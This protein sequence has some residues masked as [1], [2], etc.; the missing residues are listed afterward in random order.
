MPHN[1]YGYRITDGKAEVDE[2]QAAKVRALFEN[3]NSGMGLKAAAEKAGL[4]IYHGSAGRML[5]NTHYLGDTYYPAI[6]DKET[7]EKAEERR[8]ETAKYLNKYKE[9]K[10]QERP[11]V[12]TKF[13]MAEPTEHF[14]DPYRQAEY[15]YGL[16]ESE[17]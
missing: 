17:A 2:E 12:P 9:L 10:P 13:S 4:Q 1:P 3:Y 15:L 8:Q 14:D 16:I 11:P 6:I 7:F 5:R